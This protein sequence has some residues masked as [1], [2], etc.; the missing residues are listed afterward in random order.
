MI[1]ADDKFTDPRAESNKPNDR[2][3]EPIAIV[4]AACRLP[5]GVNDLESYWRVLEGGLDVIEPFPSERWNAAKLYSP[6]PDAEGKTYCT[7]G[8][9]VHNVDRFDAAFFGIAPREAEGMDPGQR[10]ALEC[11]W[12]ALESAQI[13]PA[14]VRETQTGVFLG[15]V[16]SDYEPWGGSRGMAGMDGYGFTG[17]DGSVL[18]GRVSYTMD[19]QGPAVTINT[20]CSSSLVATHL[21]VRALRS[22]ECD[23]VVC[24]GSQVMATPGTFVEFSRLRALAKDGRCKS[25]SDGAN[26]TGWAEG[27]GVLVLQRLSDAQREKRPILAVIRGSAVNQD[28]RSNGLTVPNPDAQKRVVR[29]ALKESGLTTGD[30]DVLEAHGTGTMVGDP[31]EAKALSAVFGPE[32]TSDR[33]LYLGSAKSNIGHTQTAAGVAGLIK[34]VLALKHEKLPKSLHSEKLSSR[35]QW[36]GSGL[37]L[38]QEQR[39]WPRGSRVRRA[40]INSFGIGGT[41]AHVIIEEAPLTEQEPPTGDNFLEEM[42]ILVSGTDVTALK[43][44]AGRLAEYL[45]QHPS[46]AIADLAFSLAKTRTH[47]PARLAMPVA[48]DAQLGDVASALRGFSAGGSPPE[49][50]SDVVGRRH[51]KRVVLFPGQGSQ[52]PEMGKE[53]YARF[54]E[55]RA[56]LDELCAEI[57][58]KLPRPLLE[59]M[60]APPESDAARLL[61]ETR[62]T[63]PALFALEV[64]LFRQWEAWGLVPD[65]LLG[66]SIGELAA[67]HVAGVLSLADACTLVTARSRLMQ[68]AP[69]GGAMYAISATAAEVTEFLAG[70]EDCLSI[71]AINEPQQTVIS[72]DAS[73]AETIAA[74]LEAEGKR[75]RKLR[76]SHAFHSPHMNGILEEF[77]QVAET[78]TYHPPKIPILSNLTGK[79]VSPEQMC[80]P[81]YWVRQLRGA[82]RF[83]NA[84][85][86]ADAAGADCYVEC[87][88]RGALAAMAANCSTSA[89]STFIP[90]LRKDQEEKALLG[91]AAR[92][93][94][95]GITLDWAAVLA[96]AGARQI[97]LPTYSFQRESYWI[98]G[99]Q[100]KDKDA[101]GLGLRDVSHAMLGAEIA[102]PDGGYLFTARL[103]QTDIS[104]LPDHAIF[105]EIIVP[106]MSYVDLLAAA[107]RRMGVPQIRNLTL[108]A[109]LVLPRDGAAVL[110]VSVD[111]ASAEGQRSFRIHARAIESGSEGPWVL[112]ASGSL[113]AELALS[114]DLSL[115]TWPP[116]S[117]TSIP[118]EGLYEGLAAKGLRYG[119]AFQGLREAFRKGADVYGTLALPEDQE[120]DGYGVHPALLDAGLH[121]IFAAGQL[122]SPEVLVPFELQQLQISQAKSSREVRAH[123]AL[124]KH[125]DSGQSMSASMSIYD[126]DGHL[127]ASAMNMEFRSISPEKLRKATLLAAANAAESQPAHLY[128]VDWTSQP[129][130][131]DVPARAT[132]AVVGSGAN[133]NEVTALLRIAGVDVLRVDTASELRERLLRD[134]RRVSTVV[135]VVDPPND[136]NIG[137]AARETTTELVRELQDWTSAREFAEYRYV[138]VTSEAILPS[139]GEKNMLASAPLWGLLR[140]VRSENPQR[141]WMLLDM[142][143]DEAS[144]QV[145]VAALFASD[146]P[147]V[148]LRRGKRLVPRWEQIEAPILDTQVLDPEGTVLIT[149]GT[150]GL[151]VEV[152]RHLAKHH[153]VRHLV[154]TSRRGLNAPGASELLVELATVG[155]KAEIAACDVADFAALEAL[156]E[157]IPEAHPLTAVFHTAGVLDGGL[158]ASLTADN[159]ANVFAPKVK[160]A[161]NL[162]RLTKTRSL[163][164][165]MLFSSVAGLVGSEGQGAYAAA[166]TFLDALCQLR[167]KLGLPA[168]SLAWGPWGE[169]GMAARLSDLHKDRMRQAGFISMSNAVALRELDR[170]M[171][172]P[173][174]L[175]TPVELDREILGREAGRPWLRSLFPETAPAAPAQ[176]AQP[177]APAQ[178]PKKSQTLPESLEA[179]NTQEREHLL[180]GLVRAEVAAVLRLH[181]PDRVLLDQ[182]LQELGMDSLMAVDIRRRLEARLSM[183]LPATLAFDCPTCGAL[184]DHLLSY[185]VK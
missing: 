6:D 125:D 182:P 1:E 57:D 119:A 181:D 170:S 46:I 60:F 21:G 84:V 79:I 86:N 62:F 176:P 101:E 147:E 140:S 49:I 141:Q 63:Q 150:G 151:G 72:G 97:D 110:Q 10:I 148:A 54:P 180:L 92:A 99:S 68:S 34:I 159:V 32:R 45:D 139:Q 90:S 55:F 13:R 39:P 185:W 73:A 116:A 133:A 8:G 118:L 137:D 143:G 115:A 71:A 98:G 93:H 67:A 38:L 96:G 18:S 76:V 69:S 66:H 20:A 144:Q 50:H 56:A 124:G 127:L 70:M 155:C 105:G 146:E 108:Q 122:E 9:F 107:G 132:C 178:P 111:P 156:L 183:E 142:D 78:L 167:H 29:Q 19:F 171:Q 131:S 169:V 134:G 35:I 121:L 161:W 103:S 149:G 4:S 51:G 106:G 75:I 129:L 53:L 126:T 160:G 77:R 152:A 136:G 61:D 168:Q 109:P 112:H 43:A 114:D 165:F 74:E 173:E 157:S 31:I 5:G 7:Q 17:R 174:S 85:K 184:L 172:Q 48:R 42:P 89:K 83:L 30:I 153:G 162:H 145:F 2:T 37:K 82:V 130:T 16:Y 80:K 113:G 28:G 36:E 104:W 166:N 175:L 117:S 100:Q 27:C 12:E 41:N 94:V 120:I 95:A 22:G 47:F 123:L 87:G 24:G 138:L 135:R 158:A 81:R 154:L 88:P 163:S 11:V 40:G 59:V 23:M 177:A 25:F 179:A 128:R 164:T 52:T 33:P 26:G 44:Q 102:L 91:A 15:T 14:D 64:A 58:P 3:P 65:L